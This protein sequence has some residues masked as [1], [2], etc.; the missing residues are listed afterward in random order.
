MAYKEELVEVFRT[1]REASSVARKL[2][3][4]VHPFV[5]ERLDRT[6]VVKEHQT[7]YPELTGSWAVMRRERA[8]VKTNKARR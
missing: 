4:G 3:Q 7:R 6:Y 1:K 5:K 2:T 8:K